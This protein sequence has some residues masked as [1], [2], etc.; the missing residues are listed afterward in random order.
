M[1]L[2]YFAHVKF[3]IK[4]KYDCSPFQYINSGDPALKELFRGAILTV[5]I[6]STVSVYKIIK[7]IMRRLVQYFGS[8]HFKVMILP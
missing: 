4:P 7:K 3:F 6:V 8:F 5:W 2:V 1:L